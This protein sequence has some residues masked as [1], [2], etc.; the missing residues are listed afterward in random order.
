MKCLILEPSP[1]PILTPR[2]PN[3]QCE[4]EYENQIQDSY[5]VCASRIKFL[6]DMGRSVTVSQMNL[7]LTGT[8]EKDTRK[9][10]RG[11]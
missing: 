9:L 6:R 2:G 11:G 8:G 10:V 1:L 3:I 5:I 7:S 4:V